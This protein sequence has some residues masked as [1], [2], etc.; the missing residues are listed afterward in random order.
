MMG[1]GEWSSWARFAYTGYHLRNSLN[2]VA[3]VFQGVIPGR[4]RQGEVTNWWGDSEARFSGRK[5]GKFTSFGIIRRFSWVGAR[6]W[7]TPGGSRS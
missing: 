1:C 2:Q 4:P 7:D 6:G 3:H 5:L